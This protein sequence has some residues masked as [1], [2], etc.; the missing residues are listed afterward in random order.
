MNVT[1][2]D[3]MSVLWMNHGLCIINHIEHA[4]SGQDMHKLVPSHVWQEL[5][6]F[7]DEHG[8]QVKKPG[9]KKPQAN[10][11][12]GNEQDETELD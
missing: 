3:P 7:V 12:A 4:C 10:T 9:A 11:D 8:I 2:C 1:A 5:D 6:D